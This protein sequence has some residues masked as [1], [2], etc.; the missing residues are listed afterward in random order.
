MKVTLE[1]TLEDLVRLIS[2]FDETPTKKETVYK[3]EQYDV[4]HLDLWNFIDIYRGVNIYE[5]G[6]RGYGVCMGDF[7]DRKTLDTV[8]ILKKYVDNEIDVVAG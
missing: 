3:G 4:S 2:I 8:E 6:S 7:V 5:V 1:V